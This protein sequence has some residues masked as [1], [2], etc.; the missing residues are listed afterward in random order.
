LLVVVARAIEHHS[1]AGSGICEAGLA[2]RPGVQ[3]LT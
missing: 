2:A 3:T 1:R